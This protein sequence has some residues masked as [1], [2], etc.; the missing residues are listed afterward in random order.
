METSLIPRLP[1]P[2]VS[3]YCEWWP[4]NYSEVKWRM[5][6]KVINRNNCSRTEEGAWGRRYMETTYDST[7]VPTELL[8]LHTPLS[9]MR[10]CSYPHKYIIWLQ[11]YSSAQL[12]LLLSHFIQQCCYIVLI[13]ISTQSCCDQLFLY[14]GRVSYTR[15]D[16]LCISGILSQNWIV[17]G[18]INYCERWFHK[19]FGNITV[20]LRSPTVS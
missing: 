17:S 10:F 19:V 13:G 2:R 16:V 7:H 1:P 8:L 3:N 11:Y 5:R 15:R 4:L 20:S 9:I 12:H 18:C 14:T 6:S